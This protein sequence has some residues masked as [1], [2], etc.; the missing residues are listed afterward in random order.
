[1]TWQ[2]NSQLS[3]IIQA[4]N[5]FTTETPKLHGWVLKATSSHGRQALMM[6]MQPN[7]L[8]VY[9]DRTVSEMS[10]QVELYAP[11]A[12]G[13]QMGTAK[14]SIDPLTDL[15][16]Q[17]Q[18]L[19]DNARLALNA[20]FKLPEKSSEPYP[21]VQAAD[22][23]ILADIDSAHQHLIDRIQQQCQQL[24]NVIVNSAELFTNQHSEY[25]ITSTG[26]ETEQETTDLYFEVAMEKAPGPNDQEVLKYFHFVGLA[27][28]DVEAKLKAVAREALLAEKA[29]LP[30]M[31]N[32]ATILIDSEAISKIVSAIV[33]QANGTA[34]FA[35]GPHLKPG[36]TIHTGT[37]DHASDQLTIKLDPYEPQMAKTTAFTPE[38]LPPQRAVIIED[39][40][41]MNQIIDSRMAQTLNVSANH[42]YGNCVVAPGNSTKE[43]L[44]ALRDEVFEILDFS[45]L[46]VNPATLTWSSEIK[47]GL[48]HKKGEPTKVLK[49]GIVSGDIKA[50]LASFKFS[51]HVIK[52]NTA[53]GY[54]EAANGYMGPEHM[55]I[56]QGIS[57]AGQEEA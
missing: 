28:A 4:L 53:G 56:W 39:N 25:R 48:L 15:A 52:R 33:A 34:E 55:L 54:F 6:A 3:T 18:T 36:Q 23:N 50:S 26:I 44:L 32:S 1:M 22:P 24:S 40:A 41:V 13:S 20:Y 43:D 7:T 17:L 8:P 11:S 21:Q 30:P 42:I 35:K 29:S 14:G 37:Q 5:I 38:G 46:L 47:L 9:Q 19:H 16:T 57:I 10:F 12:D 45:S 49:G 31:R 51:N 2:N 27:D